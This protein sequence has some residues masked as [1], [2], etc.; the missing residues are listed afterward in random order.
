M[1]SLALTLPGPTLDR[2]LFQVYRHFG[3]RFNVFAE[4]F[5]FAVMDG[6][7]V[8]LPI[9]QIRKGYP[10]RAGVLSFAIYLAGQKVY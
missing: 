3:I 4:F 8:A 2:V 10:I 1:F 7:L 6:V 9:S 5:V